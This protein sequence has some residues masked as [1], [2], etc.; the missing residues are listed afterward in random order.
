MDKGKILAR[1]TNIRAKMD[2]F[3]LWEEYAS[4]AKSIQSPTPVTMN[5][6]TPKLHGN[7]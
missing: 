5:I 7:V 4:K 1:S 6:Y 2:E 3:I